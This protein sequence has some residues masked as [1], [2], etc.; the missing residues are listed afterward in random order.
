MGFTA[1]KNNYISRVNGEGF[2]TSADCA[3]FIVSEYLGSFNIPTLATLVLPA[4]PASDAL[5]EAVNAVFDAGDSPT[6]LEAKLSAALMVYW[7]FAVFGAYALNPIAGGIPGKVTT[8]N[9]PENAE[10]IED[11]VDGLVG[12]F[13]DH[14]GAMSWFLTG[15]TPLAG[16]TNPIV[17]P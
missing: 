16:P 3:D 11:F 9:I 13:E 10:S 8:G 1:F 7:S 6:I 4:P 14:I 15:S 5:V 17:V 2:A 12:M